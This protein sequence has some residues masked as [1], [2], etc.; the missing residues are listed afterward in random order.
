M[1]FADLAKGL[2]SQAMKTVGDLAPTITYRSV[3]STTYDPASGNMVETYKDYPVKA[4]LT[5]FS[6]DEKD[7]SVVV[8][9]D[10]KCLIAS[11]DLPVTPNKDDKVISKGKTWNVLRIMGVPGESLYKIH[12]REV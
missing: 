8:T 9:T 7:N 2:V 4:V 5:S 3:S 12:V 1:G 10:Q 11:A 6:L